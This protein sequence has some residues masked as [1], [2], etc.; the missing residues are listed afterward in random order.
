MSDENV[1]PESGLTADPNAEISPELPPEIDPE[2]LARLEENLARFKE[3]EAQTASGSEAPTTDL[4]G[5]EL[6]PNLAHLYQRGRVEDVDGKPTWVTAMHEYLVLSGNFSGAFGKRNKAGIYQRLD[7]QITEV[8]NGPEGIMS[9][10][11]HGWRLSAILPNGSGM[12]V[13]IMERNIKRVLPWPEPVKTETP[14]ADVKD[15]ELQRVNADAAKW[16][17][18]EQE[19]GD[20]GTQP[21]ADHPHE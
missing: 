6:D 10:R 8:V 20:A 14:V 1:I 9:I 21:N 3:S 2:A 13:A 17:A 4:S 11:D 15:E 12:G 5:L 16:A 18:G 7:D 19:G